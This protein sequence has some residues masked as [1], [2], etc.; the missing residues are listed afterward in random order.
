[1]NLQIYGIGSD[2]VEIARMRDGLHRFG[3]RF[4]QRILAED[5][6]AEFKDNRQSAHFLARRFAAK[7][8]LS[9]ALGSGFRDGVSLR[10]L[11]IGHD[12]FGKP[13]VVYHGPALETI[14]RLGISESLLSIS[15]ERDYALAFAILLRR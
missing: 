14:N 7:E 8:A 6:F 3:E 10:T 2:I 4:A 9:K 11:G 12:A 5:E 13:L 1:M 15:D